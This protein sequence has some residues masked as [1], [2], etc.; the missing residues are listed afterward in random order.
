MVAL[1]FSSL[2]F[3]ANDFP[4]SNISLRYP[5]QEDPFP[6]MG[7]GFV[8]LS[9]GISTALWNPAGLMK[10][11]SAEFDIGATTTAPPP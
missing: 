10:T 7:T 9:D 3:A 4:Y 11:R 1:V 5:G 8:S 2:A 6:G